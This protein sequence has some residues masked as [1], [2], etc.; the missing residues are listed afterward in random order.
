MHKI[1]TTGNKTA[2]QKPDAKMSWSITKFL[3][4]QQKDQLWFKCQAFF[5]NK[6]NPN[7]PN[8]VIGMPN[9][10]C[11]WIPSI[12]HIKQIWIVN[13]SVCHMYTSSYGPLVRDNGSRKKD[14]LNN[15]AM[16]EKHAQTHQ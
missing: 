15:H 12:Q 9:I 5:L 13:K 7:I 3:F 1:K 11:R 4:S 8:I 2:R 10:A 6:S 14:L 16:G